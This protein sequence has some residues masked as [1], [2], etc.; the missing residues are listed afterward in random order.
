MSLTTIQKIYTG[1]ICGILATNELNNG[2][3]HGGSLDERLPSLL[4]LVSEGLE[5]LY[6]D[7]PAGDDIEIVGN[8]LIS[9]CRHYSEAQYLISGGGGTTPGVVSGLIKSPILIRGYDFTS[10][11]SWAGTNS[12]NITIASS[13]TLQVFWN[14]NNRYLVPG[15]EWTRT[16][17][18]FDII[19]NGTTI[20][21][22]N[23][24]TDNIADTFFVSISI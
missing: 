10:A 15:K 7:D 22:F 1:N 6:N 16:A 23:A 21:A 24:T 13:Y 12:E 14:D 3:L 4:F 11:L 20:T 5:F 8:Y 9:I 17:T 18:G 19:V 2:K